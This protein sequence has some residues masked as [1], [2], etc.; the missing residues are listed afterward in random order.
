VIERKRDNANVDGVTEKVI[1]QPTQTKE[2]IGQKAQK[3]TRKRVPIRDSPEAGVSCLIY[4]G[5][6]HLLCFFVWDFGVFGRE[7]R[8]AINA[9]KN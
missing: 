8:L 9:G 5:A 1:A 2:V 6:Q 4:S 7:A 3:L